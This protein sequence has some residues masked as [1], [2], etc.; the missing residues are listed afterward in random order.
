MAFPRL[1]ILA[2]TA[3][4][5]ILCLFLPQGLRAS[6]LTVTLACFG[7]Q[8]WQVY[9]YTPLASQE[10]RLAPSA[11]DQLR[12][13]AAN[14]LMENPDHDAVARMIRREAPDVIFLMETDHIW[15]DAL[16][17]VLGEYD[18]VLT[19]PQ[20]NHYGLA[21]ATR[22]Q[23]V[24]VQLLDLGDVEKPTLYAELKDRHG[25]LFRFVG[26]HPAPPVPGQDT[27]PGSLNA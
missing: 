12:F 22:L 2:A 10:I 7:F 1:Q 16:E 15:I 20:D 21:F 9:P 23:V 26:L 14:V 19:K 5:V 18:T 11:D 3:F 4:L 13:L 27:D 24:D 8:A 17:P 6:V 25:R